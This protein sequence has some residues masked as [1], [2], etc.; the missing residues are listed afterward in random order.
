MARMA[1]RARAVLETLRTEHPDVFDEVAARWEARDRAVRT[2]D[3]TALKQ[4]Y[5]SDAAFV[6]SFVEDA[7]KE[8]LPGAV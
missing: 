1:P 4:S 5:D 8:S 3:A 7:I 6:R 2:Q